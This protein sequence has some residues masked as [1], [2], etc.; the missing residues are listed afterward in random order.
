MGRL[1]LATLASWRRSFPGNPR[2]PAH[3]PPSSTMRAR[4]LLPH[5]LRVE[6]ARLRRLPGFL[7]E[8]RSLARARTPSRE[9]PF[10]LAE[11]ATPLA[12]PG[13]TPEPRLQ[14]GKVRNVTLAAAALDGLTLAPGQ[15][16]SYLHAVG[17]PTRLRGFRTGL[18]LHGGRPA[19]GVGGGC[20][21]VSNLLYYLAL[22]GGL[23]VVERHRH[24]LDLYPDAG[25]NVPFGCG[26]TVYYNFADLRFDNPLDGA[27][28]LQLSV[29]PDG[30]GQ[31]RGQVCTRVDPGF[32]V[33]IYQS[34][35]R[36]FRAPDSGELWRENRVRRRICTPAG[37]LIAD[38]EVAHNLGR[39]CYE[40]PADALI[41][42]DD[43]RHAA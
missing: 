12:R 26:A 13:C 3:V 41:E 2:T 19:E 17:W 16:A 7:L 37:A 39:V 5:T 10:V 1:I 15:R 20:C 9:F 27:V 30:D 14:R 40:L 21:Q 42:G 35:H 18:E 25:R 23:N 38:H 33:E 34:M 29:D 6:L 32:R 36:F 11:H 43:L 28:R 8:A 31:L 22:A 4:D 24:A